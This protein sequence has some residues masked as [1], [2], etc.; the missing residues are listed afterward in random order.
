MAGAN[1]LADGL[2]GRMTRGRLTRAPRRSDLAA[3]RGIVLGLL[4]G[5]GAQLALVWLVYRAW[6]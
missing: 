1:G 2:S 6:G 5:A 4:L 3:A